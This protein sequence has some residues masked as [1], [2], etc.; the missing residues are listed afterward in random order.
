M[1][2]STFFSGV[3]FANRVIFADP[4][5]WS[6]DTGKVVIE[7]K[8]IYILREREAYPRRKRISRVKWK[9]TGASKPCH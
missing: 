9:D 3:M 1:D 5:T 6:V 2:F 7:L 4:V 8:K